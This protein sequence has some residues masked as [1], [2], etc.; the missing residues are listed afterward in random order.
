ML[1]CTFESQAASLCAEKRQLHIEYSRCLDQELE[2][3]QREV[4]SWENS[5]LFR[6]EELEKNTGR[7][8]PLRVF[9]RSRKLFQQ[10]SSDHCRWQYLAL[11]PD[12]QAGT[13]VFKECM[14]DQLKIQVTVLQQLKY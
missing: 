6:L 2:K 11:I 1:I 8:E 12:S 10:F 9:K 14:L 13:G 4:S 7:G 5:H 3:L